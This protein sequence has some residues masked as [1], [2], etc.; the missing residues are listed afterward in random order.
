MSRQWQPLPITAKLRE[1]VMVVLKEVAA[2]LSKSAGSETRPYILAEIAL[3]FAYY[4]R[5]SKA[6]R[7][8]K[9]IG[10]CLDRAA[11]QLSRVPVAAAL[12]GGYVG[13]AWI[14]R[15][16]S[17][18][19]PGGADEAAEASDVDEALLEPLGAP[20]WHESYDLVRGLVGQGV[21]F[22]E[23]LPG[24]AA[25]RG[26]AH[27][28]RHLAAMAERTDRGIT[29]HTPS[30]FLSDWQ[31]DVSPAGYYNLG[32]AHG[33]PGV[34]GLLTLIAQRA[35]EIPETSALLRDSVTWLL[36]SRQPYTVGSYYRAWL[37]ASEEPQPVKSRTAWCYGD[38]G[39]AVALI[40]S[41]SALEEPT[42]SDV[43]L[44][45][46]LA[47]C[48]G[49]NAERDVIDAILC[50]GTSGLMHLYN[51]MGQRLDNDALREAAVSWLERTLEF[52][53]PGKHIGGFARNV[54][55]PD[56]DSRDDWMWDPA[57]GFLSGTAGIGLALV[58]AVSDDEPE[59]D[60]LLLLS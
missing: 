13:V 9:L 47:T 14:D 11:D 7:H 55:R 49:S 31:R 57:A 45:I 4:A 8:E 53:A 54:P 43:G 22:L 29:W 39:P 48:R 52:H 56:R 30:E 21:Y 3:F 27:I 20:E 58:A 50:H 18:R 12:H 25:R 38:P 60:R 35:A 1:Q 41:S 42:L 2:A 6:R 34:I 44:E 23:C 10:H 36:A 33:I 59:W 24:E 5:L 46:L 17:S 37:P 26:L 15:H 51:R 19:S 40:L 16:V 28:V 32:M